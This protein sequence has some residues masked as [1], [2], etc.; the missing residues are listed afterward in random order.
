[1]EDSPKIDIKQ[2]LTLLNFSQFAPSFFLPTSP[3]LKMEFKKFEI[4]KDR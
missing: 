4:K 2:I 1:M 3:T